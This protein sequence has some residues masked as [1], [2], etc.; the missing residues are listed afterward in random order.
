LALSF[1]AVLIFGQ[2]GAI[3]SAVT[4]PQP[5]TQQQLFQENINY[6]D[7]SGCDPT[8]ANTAFSSG[9]GAGLE[10]KAREKYIFDYFVG[11]ELTP[12]G[13]A[14]IMGNIN[15]ESGFDPTAQEDGSHDAYPKD[16]VGFGLVQWTFSD[17]QDPLVALAKQ[18]GVKP[19]DL[20][21][22]LQY[23]M[24]ELKS[25]YKSVYDAVKNSNDIVNAELT[26]ETDYEA[27]AGGIQPD[28]LAA[29]RAYLS[30]YGGDAAP[31]AGPDS[32][33]VDANGACC[34]P[35]GTPAA[36]GDVQ[37]GSP[38]DWQKLYT[39]TNKSKADLLSHG[40]LSDPKILVIHYTE[41]DQEGQSLLDYFTGTPDKLGIQF[42]VGKD[43]QVYQY[44]P[45]NDMRETYHVGDANSK[46]IGIEITGHD[47][48][49]LLNDSKQFD[50][51]ASLSKFLCDYYKIPCSESK[52]DMTGDGLSTAQGM[53]GHDETPTN[54]H[55]DPDAKYGQTIIRTDSS[56]HPYMIKLRTALGFDPT[57]GQ[58][59]GA[60]SPSTVTSPVAG[61]AGPAT[62]CAAADI[63]PGSGTDTNPVGD[64]VN[65]ALA[66]EAVKY[67]TKENNGKYFYKWGGLHGPVSQLQAF[68]NNGGGTD[69]SGFV[70]YIIWK[71]YG[72]DVGSFVTGSL[73]SMSNFKEVSPSDVAAG[74][75]GWIAGGSTGH[76]DFITKN[77]G[78]GNLHQFGAHSE[79]NDLYGGKT[80]ASAYDKFFRYVG[81]KLNGEGGD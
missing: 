76:V 31:A 9:Q 60:V 8:A 32:P 47:V 6:F 78:G 3:A 65:K 44:Y 52:G 28:R 73:S 64:G 77:D 1:L 66:L 72:V 34:P 74:D 57:P 33:G 22:Q 46:S 14:A 61:A 80:K 5:L 75:I 29:A 42:N 12:A 35:T 18:A 70:R 54:D 13:A 79:E 55:N 40:K 45:L 20:D 11:Q 58:K 51:V 59:D 27:H 39:G 19:T 50:A 56:K 37:D 63:A 38:A 62:G 71:V 48:N 21:I 15:A 17:R 81:P 41:G 69:C 49:D 53:L 25:G 2:F 68:S 7:I 30:E 10:G 24:Q 67:D 43:G 16:G 23:V 36:G 4:N 26:V